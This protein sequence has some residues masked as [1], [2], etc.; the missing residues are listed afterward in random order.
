MKI[1]SSFNAYTQNASDD[2]EQIRL[3]DFCTMLDKKGHNWMLSNSDTKRL[4]EDMFFD[5]LYADYVINR[6]KAK[7]SI[8]SNAN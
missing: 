5:D 7:R 1:T 3:R 6:V 8:N 4:Y 2:K